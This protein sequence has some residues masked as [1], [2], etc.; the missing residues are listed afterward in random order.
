MNLLHRKL[1][2]LLAVIVFPPV[3]WADAPTQLLGE[4][5]V[6]RNPARVRATLREEIIATESLSAREIEKSG[7]TMLT[8]VLDKRPG[9]SVQNECSL[10]NSRN[11]LLNNLPGRFTTVLIDG[12]PI[13]SS[14]SAA[15]GLDSVSLGGVERIDVARG[16]GA[17][18]IAPEALAGTVSI[19]TRRPQENEFKLNQQFGSYGQVLSDVFAAGVFPGG[20]LT[21]NLSQSRH[22]GVD[23]DGNGVSE[24]SGFGRK[25]AGLGVFVDDLGGFKLRSR[26]DVVD[27]KRMGG[28]LGT[29][30]AGIKASMR[31]NPFNWRAGPHG[32]SSALGWVAVN[33]AN[34]DGIAGNAD[35]VAPGGILAYGQGRGGMAEIIFTRRQQF[36]ASGVRPLGEGTL[37]LAL[38]LARHQQDS[39]YEGARYL[40]EQQQYYLEASTQQPLAGGVF[41]LGLNYRYED[42][43]SQGSNA[44]GV[45]NDGIDNYRYRTPGVFVQGYKAFFDQQLELNASLRV[46]QHN[47]F[48]SIVSPRLN[49]L[50]T[51]DAEL[52]S[53][54]SM[55]RGF[56][57]PTSFF[58][59]DHGILDTTRIVRKVNKPEISDNLSY[60]LSY[61]GDRLAWNGGLTYNRI[62]HMAMLDAAAVDAGGNPITLFSS[63][64]KPV[65]V[66]SAD[67]NLSYKL[68]ANLE[69]TLGL[70]RSLYD[71]EPGTLPFARPEKRVY[72]SLDFDHGPFDL[73][74]RASWTGAQDLARFYDYANIPRYNFDGTTKR[75]RSPAFWVFDL[76]GEYKLDKS[77]SAYLGVDNLLDYKQADKESMLWVDGA[78]AINTTQIWGPFRGRFIYAGVKLAL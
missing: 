57:A 26:F 18:L 76:R 73:I 17:S 13:F 66:K 72:L 58:E 35:D 49:L 70:E 69:G 12:I 56:R 21:A 16:A 32:S 9:V 29:D 31:G 20:A 61:A 28:P 52:N 55:G 10:C 67:L 7:G 19:V 71:F 62:H 47:V 75:K 5:V 59:Q 42:L 27:E 63:A 40:A 11:I 50:W 6:E 68:L 74:A 44:S 51:H 60:V 1:A 77:W 33:G 64:L 65:T 43:S 15:Y 46:D 78:G 41:T 48:G 36:I 45:V 30:Y 53:R 2:V 23:A 39:F 4:V 3:L 54:I 14:V 25:L 34:P 8:E 37:R 22:D 38:G 24:Y